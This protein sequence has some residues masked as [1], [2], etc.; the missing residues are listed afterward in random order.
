MDNKCP[1]Y[2]TLDVAPGI[3][4]NTL[5]WYVVYLRKVFTI[6]MDSVMRT[7]IK[8]PGCCLSYGVCLC[9]H[10]NSLVPAI[11]GHCVPRNGDS[12]LEWHF[13]TK[14]QFVIRFWFRDLTQIC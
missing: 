7:A 9:K 2:H 10:I 5:A 1:F 12:C 11:G 4:E 14:S 13:V 8:K 3:L 6:L